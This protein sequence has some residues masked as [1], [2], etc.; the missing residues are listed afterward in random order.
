MVDMDQLDENLKAM[1]SAFTEADQK[2]LSA[3]LEQIRPLYC[4]M[5][6]RC[7]G[8]CPKGMPVPDV[9]RYLTYAEGY[10]QFA[11]GREKFLELPSEVQKIRCDLCPSCSVSCSFGVKVAERLI[12]AQELLA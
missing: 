1:A 12:R 7:E 6:N 8:T 5:C 10:G 9:L 4:R 2:I 3:R 11:L